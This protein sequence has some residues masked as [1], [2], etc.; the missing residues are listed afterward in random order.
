MLP[1]DELGSHTDGHKPVFPQASLVVASEAWMIKLRRLDRHHLLAGAIVLRVEILRNI[2]AN[3]QCTVSTWEPLI[4]LSFACWDYWYEGQHQ[5]YPMY[6][7]R[8]DASIYDML[9]QRAI[10]FKLR[11]VITVGII[12]LASIF[13]FASSHDPRSTFICAATLHNRWLI[14]TLQRLGTVLDAFIA[15]WIANMLD[16][17]KDTK[18]QPATGHAIISPPYTVGK[19]LLVSDCK[20]IRISK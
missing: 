10:R 3:T 2:L 18:R 15:F 13:A 8:P 19:V 20:D 5:A 6:D 7:E 16:E 9:K 17:T 12:S 4:P 1:L 14:P 11:H